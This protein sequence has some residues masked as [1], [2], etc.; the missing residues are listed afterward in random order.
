MYEFDPDKDYLHHKI[1]LNYMS[2]F[3]QVTNFT[4]KSEVGLILTCLNGYI[5][6]RDTVDFQEIWSNYPLIANENRKHKR[7][8]VTVIDYCKPLDL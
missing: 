5:E 8:S 1:L 4:Y 6:I 7:L 3:T 2:P